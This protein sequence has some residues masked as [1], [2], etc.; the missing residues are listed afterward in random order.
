M[1]AA[2][3][4]P[5]AFPRLKEVER[6]LEPGGVFRGV[7]LLPGWLVTSD[8]GRDSGEDRFSWIQREQHEI[9]EDHRR[10]AKDLKDSLEKRVTSILHSEMMSNLEV[11]DA[12]NLVKLHC[13]TAED[14]KITFFLPEGEIEEYGVEECKEV[15]KVASKLSHIQA[16]GLNFDTR[17]AHAYMGLLKKAVLEGVWNGICPDWFDVTDVEVGTPFID[18]VSLLEIRAEESTNLESIF[19]M[20][21]SNGMVRNVRLSEKCV[22]KSFYSNKVLYDIAQPPSCA[23][24]SIGHCFGERRSRG[25]SG[26]FLQC[27]AQPTAVRWSV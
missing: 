27:H 15:M 12:A 20:R 3:A 7:T 13:G 25:N 10:F 1:K 17:M 2:N 19:V 5:E 21:F 24:L 14:G 23:L 4:D 11:F 16:S 26:K 18:G 6:N 8:G 9:K 22:Y